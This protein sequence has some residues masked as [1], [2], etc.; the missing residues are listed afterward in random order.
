MRRNRSPKMASR[1]VTGRQRVSASVARRARPFRDGRQRE[2]RRR[3][4]NSAP[5]KVSEKERFHRFRS[6][7]DGRLPQCAWRS[8]GTS[9]GRSSRVSSGCLDRRDRECAG[10]LGATCRRRRCRRSA[11]PR[12]RGLRRPSLTPTVAATPRRRPDV[13]AGGGSAVAD[14]VARAARCGAACLTGGGGHAGQP[15]PGRLSR[16]PA[17]PPGAGLPGPVIPVGGKGCQVG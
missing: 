3:A 14:A 12:A 17:D 10:R 9:S 4:P 8:S 1:G 11:A 16:P 15:S 7:I 13:R 2:R 5:A 6:P